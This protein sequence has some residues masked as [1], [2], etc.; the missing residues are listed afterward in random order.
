[1]IRD[2]LVIQKLVDTYRYQDNELRCRIESILNEPRKLDGPPKES[3]KPKIDVADTTPFGVYRDYVEIYRA[4][5]DA[6]PA[7]AGILA[8]ESGATECDYETLIALKSLVMCG[9]CKSEARAVACRELFM[10][11]L[12]ER[13]AGKLDKYMVSAVLNETGDYYKNEIVDAII[14]CMYSPKEKIDIELRAALKGDYSSADLEL[15]SDCETIEDFNNKISMMVKRAK[16]SASFTSKPR[17]N[18]I[19]MAVRYMRKENSNG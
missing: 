3:W 9:I 6:S 8:L 15:F 16:A 19:A 5:K 10:A 11:L 13:K 4:L 14:D 2:Q 12:K 18:K 17:E 1:M 7:K